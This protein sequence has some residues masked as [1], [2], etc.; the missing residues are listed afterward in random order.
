MSDTTN[1][2]VTI[3]PLGDR[4]VVRPLEMEQV[5]ASGIVI[6]DTASGEKPQEGMVIA[7]GPGEIKD[8]GERKPM[9]VKE[10]DKV[11]FGK[12]AGDEV[13]LKDENGKD[14]EVKILHEDSILGIVS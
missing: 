7:V 8:N 5:T 6:P 4:V 10:G 3:T 14:V 9:N 13:K 12:Y 2:K 1:L 11:L